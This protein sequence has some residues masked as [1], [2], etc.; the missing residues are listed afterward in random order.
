[1]WERDN[2]V[3]HAP[4]TLGRHATVKSVG[5][6]AVSV[7]SSSPRPPWRKY[8]LCLPAL[9]TND[10]LHLF[11]LSLVCLVVL[12]DASNRIGAKRKRLG[13]GVAAWKDIGWTN[14]LRV[15]EHVGD[16]QFGPK[17]LAKH[18]MKRGR[19]LPLTSRVGKVCLLD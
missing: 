5:Y 6:V 3:R 19:I 13:G 15:S 7:G 1:M 9:R 10:F 14:L 17:S 11:L 8:Q 12:T 16:C 4:L 2:Q 18:A